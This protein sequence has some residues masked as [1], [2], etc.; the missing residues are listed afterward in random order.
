MNSNALKLIK[1]ASKAYDSLL[2]AA[3]GPP[4]RLQAVADAGA[5]L[6]AQVRSKNI[7]ENEVGN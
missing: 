4:E 1:S 2:D 3:Y 5:T 7:F 6:W